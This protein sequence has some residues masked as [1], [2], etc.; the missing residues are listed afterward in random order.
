[1]DFVVD[2]LK[3]LA[4]L[5]SVVNVVIVSVLTITDGGPGVMNRRDHRCKSKKANHGA[6]EAND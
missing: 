3:A 6:N 4:I 1:M 2:F 5:E